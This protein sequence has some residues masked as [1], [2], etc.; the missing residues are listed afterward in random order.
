MEEKRSGMLSQHLS[1]QAITLFFAFLTLPTM[2]FQKSDGA[3]FLS[4]LAWRVSGS[5]FHYPPITVCNVPTLPVVA[6]IPLAM[7]FATPCRPIW[8]TML[9]SLQYE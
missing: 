7:L 3:Y 8:S 2:A 1:R 9:C 6:N 4:A 5:R